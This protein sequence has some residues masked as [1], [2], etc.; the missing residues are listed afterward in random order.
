MTFLEKIQPHLISDDLLI[1]ETVLRSIHD[2]PNLP[3]EWT[4][5]LLREAFKNKEKQ[6]S[7]F[8]YIDHQSF[9]DE[10]IKILT[11]NIPGVDQSNLP[12]ALSLLGQIEP[13]LALKNKDQL[14]PFMTNDVWPFYELLVN[15][16]KEEVY[17]K[18]L[19]AV[20]ALDQADS[21][22]PEE[23]IKAKKLAACIVNKGWITED[24]IDRELQKE[25]QKDWFSFNGI[26][27]VFM[28]G[29]LKLEKYI[30]TLSRLLDREDDT[31]LEEVSAALICFQSDEVVKEVK[32]YL[33]KDESAIYA[34]SIV[35][36][37]KSDLAVQVL[38]DAYH[39]V[40]ELDSQDVLIEA[41]CH[42]FSVE[43]LPEI[44]DHMENEYF[45]GLVDMEHTVYSYYTILGLEHPDLEKWRQA[46]LGRELEF[47]GTSEESS[48]GV[49]SPFRIDN[50]VGR[51]DPCSCGSGKKYKKC[52]GK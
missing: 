25:L 26:L 31:L 1:Q 47:R 44:K 23:Y 19:E 52:C 49:G 11:D 43:A 40:E 10:S 20:N 39:Q 17:P 51:N 37:I 15:G 50:K 12:L 21:F 42:Q 38:K 32:P 48:E 28:I 7:I 5:E 13:E 41:L 6:P 45:S 4:N 22:Q 34:T 29:L 9:N 24:E 33:L 30:P 16:T 36:N 8:V 2:Y 14:E 3:V 46:A 18:F 27:T 35:E